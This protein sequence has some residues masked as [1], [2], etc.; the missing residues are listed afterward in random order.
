MPYD[1]SIVSPPLAPEAIAE[2]RRV[3][4]IVADVFLDY[5]PVLF[6]PDS[7]E[8]RAQD[9]FPDVTQADSN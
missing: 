5:D 8:P 4:T 2:C 3:Q 1:V 6:E 7:D 9:R